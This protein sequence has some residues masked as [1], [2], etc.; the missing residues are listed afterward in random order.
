MLYVQAL[1]ARERGGVQRI[2]AVGSTALARIFLASLVTRM[3]MDVRVYGGTFSSGGLHVWPGRDTGAVKFFGLIGG[4]NCRN[5]HR[6]AITL[7]NWS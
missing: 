3:N 1:S 7:N 5:A 4:C 2:F 6:C